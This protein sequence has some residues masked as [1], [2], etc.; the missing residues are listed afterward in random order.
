MV[1]SADPTRPDSDSES[2]PFAAQLA[3]ARVHPS[4]APLSAAGVGYGLDWSLTSRWFALPTGRGFAGYG[5]ARALR[6]L[7]DVLAGLTAL[8]E[9][10]TKGGLGFV[11]GEVVPALLRV[12]LQGVARLSP[13]AP[14]H[15]ATSDAPL[16]PHSVGYLAPE[17]LLGDAIDPRADVFSAGVL[18]WEALAGRRLF[19]H[20]SV[21]QIITRLMG[22]K[23][24]LPELPPE[25][26]WAIPLKAV[27][28]RALAV[29]PAQRFGDC[30]QLAT[31]I[32][33]CARGRV[34]SHVEVAAHFNV[35]VR[36][37][38]P[39]LPRS[40]APPKPA[41]PSLNQE[42]SA[43]HKSSLSAMVAPTESAPTPVADL[44]IQAPSTRGRARRGAWTVTALIS[45]FVALGVVAF[46]RHEQSGS[47]HGT[48]PIA[49]AAGATTPERAAAVPVA[50]LEPSASAAPTL[51]VAAPPAI[52]A[53]SAHSAGPVRPGR[54]AASP[55]DSKGSGTPKLGKSP[56]AAKRVG[57]EAEQYGI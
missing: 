43:S 33:L 18:L 31:A 57:N 9:T 34:A 16:S 42:F 8:H 21:E 28:V 35:P 47:L 24:L 11:H 22:G 30:R 44:E 12:D 39:P 2:G 19:E 37:S 3:L 27:A 6:M 55:R 48:P 20:D 45:L 40:S 4:L 50:A 53:H 15:W 5:L 14:W 52:P 32:A 10:Q 41:R 38:P 1:R 26:A 29:D 51:G 46:T 17:R 36:S 56:A 49:V 54:P 13:L 25:L 7:L 23:M